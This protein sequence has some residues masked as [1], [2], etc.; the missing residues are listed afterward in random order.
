[1]ELTMAEAERRLR[2][3]TA[4]HVRLV[5]LGAPEQVLTTGRKLIQT[6]AVD[7]ASACLVTDPAATESPEQSYQP[8]QEQ[9]TKD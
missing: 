9:H 3:R 4:Q 8:E 6:S 1:M 5:L 2:N 7:L